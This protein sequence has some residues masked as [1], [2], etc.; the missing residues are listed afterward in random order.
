MAISDNDA[1]TTTVMAWRRS[2]NALARNTSISAITAPTGTDVHG[3]PRPGLIAN[4]DETSCTTPTPSK[5]PVSTRL[6]RRATSATCSPRSVTSCGADSTGDTVSPGWPGARANRSRPVIEPKLCRGTLAIH[7]PIAGATRAATSTAIS[8]TIVMRC[9]GT[10]KNIRTVAAPN[11]AAATVITAAAAVQCR[12]VN[13]ASINEP[14]IVTSDA[15]KACGAD[16]FA[17]CGPVA[18]ASAAATRAAQAVPSTTERDAVVREPI[19]AAST[20][21]VAAAA[22]TAAGTQLPLLAQRSRHT[23]PAATA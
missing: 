18:P 11:P 19:N 12:P 4:H 1:A 15:R 22:N 8:I 14:T 17:P 6:D 2:R 7:S 10:S 21:T 16:G 5:A 13:R 23:I 9:P 3:G 20:S